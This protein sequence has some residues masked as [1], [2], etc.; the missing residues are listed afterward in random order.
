M[1]ALAHPIPS[2]HNRF[3]FFIHYQPFAHNP[4]LLIFVLLRSPNILCSRAPCFHHLTFL[5]LLYLV[6]RLAKWE[7]MLLL[8]AFGVS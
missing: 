6:L 3:L 7:E 8:G 1:K 4:Q 2:D 5:Y